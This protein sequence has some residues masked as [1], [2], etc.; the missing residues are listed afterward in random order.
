MFAPLAYTKTYAMAA[1]AALSVTLVPVLMGYF[2]R[3]KVLPEQRNPLNRALV[4]VYMPLLQKV[5]RY[6]KTTLL[7]AALV[8][9]SALW[10]LQRIGSEFI[11]PLD[12]GDL[13]YMPT[14]YPGISVGKAR[15]LLQQTDKL[16]RTVPE[17][18]TVF[19]KIGRA[20][21]ATDPAPLTMIETFIQLKPRSEWRPGVTTASLTHELDA[22]VK[23]P[24]LTNAWVMPIKT[25][26]DMLATGIKT[27]VGIKVAGPSL[28][29]I[30]QIGQQLETIL[31]DVP[32]TASVFS[33]RV[34]GGR[35]IKVDINRER[36]ARFGLNIAD[37]QQVVAT[38]VGGMDI[39]RTVEGRERYPVNIRYPQSYRN[40]P[41]QLALL[42]VIT[43]A[44]QRIA[45]GDVASV[46]IEDGPPGIKS[47]NARLNGW[48]YVDI[49]GVDVGSYVAN[50]RA[51]VAQRLDLPP[52]YSLVWSGQYEYMERAR[53]RLAYVVPLT[54]AIIVVLLYLNF[55]NVSQVLIL[56]GALPLALVGSVWLMYLL[57]YSFSI[58]VGVG[59]I[60][61]AGVA[62]ET[63]VIMLVYLD[64]A[65]QRLLS[66]DGELTGAA[67]ELAV[68]EGA[69]LRVRPVLMTATA[70]IV[71]LLPILWGS[72]TG[73]EVMSRLAAPMV[74]GM[75][76]AVLLTLLVLPVIYLLWRRRQ[77]RAGKTAATD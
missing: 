6:P 29:T 19:G 59:M 15:Q 60:A 21:T 52:G 8:L 23:L 42:P 53:A 77:L 56:I 36:A 71:G 20:D 62:V 12:E 37:V 11:P 10:P 27:P 26:I 65:W 66:R 49:E 63:G 58:A 25:R 22:L 47:E 38:A 51:E 9:L 2:I 76:S 69:G 46:Y 4:R 73:S 64:Q 74:G 35:Y 30:Q 31:A 50:A 72:G 5:L 41:E 57:D 13:M 7:V 54:L 16:I 14:T 33:E 34:A 39:T 1:A 45:L 17:V 68:W 44:G 67:L 61:L 32:G 3:G 40:S 75:L 43:P 48:T 24:G 55:R 18:A 28:A 70:T